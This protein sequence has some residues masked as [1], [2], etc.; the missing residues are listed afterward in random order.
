MVRHRVE[1]KG[2]VLDVDKVTASVFEDETL[3]YTRF[4][5]VTEAQQLVDDANAQG[6]IVHWDQGCG[7]PYR[8]WLQERN[9]C[10]V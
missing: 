5:T 2:H 3:L 10:P 6:F 1:I 7:A 8:T 9:P 4:L